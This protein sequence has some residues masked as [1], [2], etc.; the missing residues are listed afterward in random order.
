[1][2]I[3]NDVTLSISF[4]HRNCAHVH[5]YLLHGIWRSG[6]VK[7]AKEAVATGQ[8]ADREIWLGDCVY[9]CFMLT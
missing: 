6:V 2:F 8:A 5:L 7:V 1:M 9:L 3:Y 4:E